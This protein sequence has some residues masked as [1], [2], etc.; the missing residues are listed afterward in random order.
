MAEMILLKV[1]LRCVVI[2]GQT[3]LWLYFVKGRFYNR[4]G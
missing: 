2:H 1:V 4:S 3:V